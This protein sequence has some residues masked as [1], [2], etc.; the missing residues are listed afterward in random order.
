ML[1]GMNSG[2]AAPRLSRSVSGLPMRVTPLFALT[3][4]SRV[5]AV[6][7][8]SSGLS[9]CNT[10]CPSQRAPENRCRCN[11]RWS[12]PP[13]SPLRWLCSNVNAHLPTTRNATLPDPP[14][15]NSTVHK[16]CYEFFGVRARGISSRT[17]FGVEFSV[18]H[19]KTISDSHSIPRAAFSPARAGSPQRRQRYILLDWVLT[20]HRDCLLWYS[21]MGCSLL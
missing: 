9:S 15:P 2:L 17:T 4:S 6:A 20:A 16:S 19:K 11:P 13:C 12:A 3:A 1:V 7:V 21:P 14:D 10:R 5:S 18:T 8:A